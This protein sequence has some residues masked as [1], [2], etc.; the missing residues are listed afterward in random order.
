MACCSGETPQTAYRF[1]GCKKRSL[2][3][4]QV[5]DIEIHVEN[6]LLT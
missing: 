3:L 2:E 1:L 6:C 5:V 4:R